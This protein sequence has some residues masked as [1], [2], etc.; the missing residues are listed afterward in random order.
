M[1]AGE[2]PPPGRVL[3]AFGDS[4]THGTPPMPALG[5]LGRHPPGTRWPD[6]A[7]RRL[8]WTVLAEGLPGRTTVHDDP[9][10][11]AH[12]N[13]LTV[14]PALL[15]SHRPLDVVAILLGTN[16]LK[17]RYGLP[18]I[19]IA[20]GLERLARV[21]LASTAGPGG[22]APG[23][24]LI[25]PVPIL[26]AGCLAEVFAGGAATSRALAAHLAGVAARLG[27]PFL[28]AGGV[29]GVDPLDGVHLD[30]PAHAALGEAVAAAVARHWP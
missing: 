26:E 10:E 20:L 11:G 15:E 13:G 12:R 16:D 24:L 2:D 1:T 30:L 27:V 6:V 25:A 18:A 4:N 19:D 21:V 23:V 5:T 8:G 7:A 14:L 29:A 9:I 22:A 28:D 17:A 3:M